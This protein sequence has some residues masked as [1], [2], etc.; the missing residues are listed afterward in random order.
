M[1]IA[2]G[3]F[4]K[5]SSTTLGAAQQNRDE[6]EIRM[7]ARKSKNRSRSPLRTNPPELFSRSPRASRHYEDEPSNNGPA[8]ARGNSP[9]R[10]GKKQS[11]SPRNEDRPQQISARK[12]QDRPSGSD[13]SA[14]LEWLH[15]NCFREVTAIEKGLEAR[16][17]A[18]CE[19]HDFT[20]ETAFAIFADSSVVRLGVNELI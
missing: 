16:K 1:D 15:K 12:Q 8:S 10:S 19:R 2:F 11:I 13:T 9:L 18:L 3:Q 5:P 7:S 17:V 14:C 6:T 4:K 20:L